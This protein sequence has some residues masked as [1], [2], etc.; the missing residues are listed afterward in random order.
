M[1]IEC[2]WCGANLDH[3]HASQLYRYFSVSEA[4][5][6]ILTNGIE[7]RFYSD[8]EQPNKMDEKPFF[9]FNLQTFDEKSIEELKKFAKHAFQLDDILATA[10]DLKY[11]NA[12]KKLLAEEWAGPSEDLIKF[13]GSRVYSGRMTQS[14]VE[15]F[16]KI[17]KDALSQFIREKVDDRLKSALAVDRESTQEEPEDSPSSE[18][19]DRDDGIV[20]TQEEIDGFNIVRAIGREIVTVDRIF[21]RDTKSYCGVLLDDN[22]R[23][24]ICRLRFNRSNKYIGLFANKKEEKIFIESLED[25]FQHAERIKA[26]ISEY[27]SDTLKGERTE[28]D[29]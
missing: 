21:M 28:E 5:F 3:E 22:N 11:T 19:A 15:Q 7:Y 6:G 24:P 20:T 26:T 16:E 18:E 1:L 29:S 10:S 25:I 2:K 17:V 14:V 27:E 8:L 12:I 23:K 13:F 4:R 9:V